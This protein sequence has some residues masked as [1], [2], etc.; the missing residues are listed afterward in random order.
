ML[1]I[2]VSYNLLSGALPTS[3]FTS[4]TPV[5]S[6]EVLYLN[7]DGNLFTSLPSTFLTNGFTTDAIFLQLLVS[8]VS[9][10]VTGTIPANLFRVAATNELLRSNSVFLALRYNKLTGTIPDDIMATAVTG[11]SSLFD[12]SNNRFIGPLPSI[13]P[14]TNR[15]SFAVNDN[16]MNGTIPDAWQDCGWQSIIL[17]RNARITGSIPPKLLSDT[18]LTSFAVTSTGLSGNLPTLPKTL[19]WEA[20][21]TNID[22]CSAA[23]LAGFSNYTGST[24]SLLTTRTCECES[25]YAALCTT[26]CLVINC[27]GTAPSPQFNCSYG[28]WTAP[29][30]V[31]TTTLIIPP[32]LGT[33]VVS[34][35]VSTPG[36]TM[37]GLGSTIEVTNLTQVHVEISLTETGKLETSS[38]QEILSLLSSNCSVDLNTVSL[39]A[40]LKGKNCRKLSVTKVISEDGSTMSGLFSLDKSNCNRWWIILV[41]VICGVIVLIVIALAL[42]TAL[43]PAFRAKI[44]PFAGRR[45]KASEL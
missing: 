35:N 38:L 24:C 22:F 3:L 29:A 15:I 14:K 19:N 33:V 28:V 31:N 25:S 21:S 23:S 5:A 16:D 1:N 27:T 32:G 13:C 9:N 45:L 11:S 40:N 41:S 18:G 37:D 42:M 30:G 39:V 26:S 8:L 2:D 34:G 44:R 4:V 12:F 20:S 17:S 36:I 10:S 7:L 43:W 6:P